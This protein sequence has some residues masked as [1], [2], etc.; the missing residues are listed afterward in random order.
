[1]PPQ[2]D[3]TGLIQEAQNG[4]PPVLLVEARARLGSDWRECDLAYETV[5]IQGNDVVLSP[6]TWLRL[7]HRALARQ[8]GA[9]PSPD[10]DLLAPLPEPPLADLAHL[11]C[12]IER[13]RG[14]TSLE[15]V[16]REVGSRAYAEI[17]AEVWDR[18]VVIRRGQVVG[19]TAGTYA[20]GLRVIIGRRHAEATTVVMVPTGD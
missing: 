1:M 7:L 5:L 10:L 3:I 14:H 18:P 13:R 12:R 2:L 15:Q 4:C 17:C 8:Q 16:V 6:A 9:A 20:I 11:L 19:L